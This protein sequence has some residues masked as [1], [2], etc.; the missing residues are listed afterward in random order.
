MKLHWTVSRLQKKAERKKHVKIK[1]LQILEPAICVIHGIY[2]FP[3]CYKT[4]HGW[5]KFRWCFKLVLNYKF[6]KKNVLYRIHV[7]FYEETFSINCRFNYYQNHL[8]SVPNLK[9]LLYEKISGYRNTLGKK[10]DK[11]VTIHNNQSGVRT[12]SHDQQRERIICKVSNQILGQNFMTTERDESQLKPTN[13][14]LPSCLLASAQV[15]SCPRRIM[16]ASMTFSTKV[17]GRP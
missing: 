15:G 10:Q 9:V 12:I 13:Q 2:K 14:Q 17:G 1:N 11:S 6:L 5:S 4:H 8:N 7:H 3:N 16:T